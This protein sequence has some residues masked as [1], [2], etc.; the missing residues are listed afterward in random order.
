[1]VYRVRG[2]AVRAVPHSAMTSLTAPFLA[3]CLGGHFWLAAP[4]GVA[5]L[6]LVWARHRRRRTGPA[7]EHLLLPGLR[8]LLGIGVPAAA[9]L[10]GGTPLPAAALVAVLVGE[11]FDRLAFYANLAFLGPRRQADLDALSMR[12]L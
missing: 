9:W 11:A 7:G 4:A 12:R 6:W 8:L 10:M 1:M 5:K 2:L 3:G